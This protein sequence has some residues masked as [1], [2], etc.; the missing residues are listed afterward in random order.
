MIFRPKEMQFNV[1]DIRYLKL[2]VA[3]NIQ[4]YI[5]NISNGICLWSLKDNKCFSKHG[6][7]SAIAYYNVTNRK[8]SLIG[9][10]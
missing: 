8:T 7:Y 9:N 5:E 10:F 2:T 3:D 1:Q 6:S 4:I